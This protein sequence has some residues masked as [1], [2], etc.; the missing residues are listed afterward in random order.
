MPTDH[1]HREARQQE[2]LA[3]LD[4]QRVTSQTQL[5]ELLRERGV[6]ATQSSVSRDLR[7]L[8]VGWIGGRYA[9]PSEREESD[10]GVTE[11]SQF[12]RGVKPAGPHLTVV[13]TMSGAAQAVG[14]AIDRAGWPEL[15]GTMA[16]DDTVFVAT[17]SAGDQKRFIRR[18][19]YFLQEG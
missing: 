13:F 12:L 11:V 10:P 18:L 16:G 9:R 5:V 7:D 14:V 17:A 19:D 3:I 1:E 8:G 6:G 4:A 15:V 2:I